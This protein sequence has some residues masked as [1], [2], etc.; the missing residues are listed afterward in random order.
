VIRLLVFILLAPAVAA[1]TSDL[2]PPT[3]D[4]PMP[5]D[6]ITT[7]SDTFY[8]SPTGNNTTGDGSIE[9]PW[10]DLIGAR[11][12]C[13]PGDI[14]YLREGYYPA[15][16]FLAGSGWRTSQNYI[17]DAGTSSDMIV[18]TN[19]PGEIARYS[20]TDTT[21]CL[22]LAGDYQA[23]V[24]SMVGAEYGIQ[25][26]GGVS[27]NSDYCQ[28]SNI[29]FSNGTGNGGD[30]NPAMLS[31]PITAN[32]TTISHNYFHDANA[33]SVPD[34]G[35]RIRAINFFANTGTIIEY[36]LF[37]DNTQAGDLYGNIFLKDYT[38]DITIRY[39]TFV[40]TDNAVSFGVQG[41]NTT[42]M[43]IYNNLCYNVLYTIVFWSDLGDTGSIDVN[44]NVS[45]NIPTGGAFFYYLNGDNDDYLVHGDYYD[46]II[47]GNAL[48]NG[49]AG[50]TDM[51]NL[52]D[53]WDYN[54][55]YAASNTNTPSGWTLPDE[56]YNNAIVDADV[57]TYYSGTNQAS[58]ADDYSGL[59]AG[60][61]GGNIGGFTF[62][63]ETTP[64]GAEITPPSNLTATKVE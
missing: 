11:G 22:S 19:Y 50:S 34:Y 15:Y 32:Y 37:M 20:S 14:I 12:N 4:R 48:V 43:S 26:T 63:G 60:R 2:F 51:K 6:F 27:L 40:N 35:S 41:N 30:F 28:I 62:D 23:L 58:V 46:N 9:N 57:V 45:I 39:N 54:L 47:D 1:A 8:C 13:G 53:Y 21:W 3:A 16:A 64:P 52:P 5:G 25:I 33:N 56:Y 31:G 36:N 38:D 59:G 42:N 24:G 29:E 49:W 18:I 7:P 17:D 10:V 44:E 61:T 55:Y